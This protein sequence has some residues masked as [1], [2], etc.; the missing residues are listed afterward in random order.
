MNLSRAISCCFEGQ[1]I[2]ADTDDL[3]EW[4]DE[5]I[6]PSSNLNLS[7]SKKDRKPGTWI[8]IRLFISSTFVD[9][10]SER[11]LIIRRVIPSLNR[12]LADKFIRVIP[13][14]LR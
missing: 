12:K 7:V 13:V 14:D 2:K 6:N 11:D 8:E 4:L 9:T 3:K 10:H 1:P 5:T